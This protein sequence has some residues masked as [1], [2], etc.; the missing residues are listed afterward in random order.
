ME[1]MDTTHLRTH[2]PL[3]TTANPS[4]T[5]TTRVLLQGMGRGMPLVPDRQPHCMWTQV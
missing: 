4:S 5:L 2:T 3:T 1:D